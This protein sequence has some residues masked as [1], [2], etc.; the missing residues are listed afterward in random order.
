MVHSN[1]LC[2]RI[3]FHQNIFGGTSRHSMFMHKILDFF[4]CTTLGFLSRCRK[5]TGGQP[6]IYR[7]YQ[8]ATKKIQAEILQTNFEIT[9]KFIKIIQILS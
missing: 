5:N 1:I 9:P 4:F 7:S 2:S 3:R 6:D 8:W